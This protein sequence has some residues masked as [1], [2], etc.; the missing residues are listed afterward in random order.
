MGKR[1][2]AQRLG[3]G[4]PTFKAAKRKFKLYY[5]SNLINSKK[6]VTG[7]VRDLCHDRGRGA[8]VAIIETEF[9]ETFAIAAVQGMYIGQKILMG[10]NVPI[11]NANILPLEKIPEGTIVSSIELNPG[12]G[13]KIAKSSGAYAIVVG[14]K[15]DKVFLRLP[16]KK[17]IGVP[18]KSLAIIG[19]VAGGGRIEKPF[20]K[21]GKKYHW[22]KAKGRPYPRVRGVAM[23]AALHPF[24]GGSHKRPGGPTSVKRT[25]PPG[26]KVGLIAPKRTGRKRGTQKTQ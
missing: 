9:G 15:E 22:M 25:A 26:Q 17:V 23:A 5:P 11:E 10:E 3:R 18:S 7:I 13:G 8:P 20:L 19:V 4:S 21:A 2:R 14:K 12:D 1:I 6:L 24:G 16:S